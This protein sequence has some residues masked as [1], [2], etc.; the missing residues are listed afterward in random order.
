MINAQKKPAP[1][2]EEVAAK[3]L[4]QAKQ[5]AARYGY[6]EPTFTTICGDLC[7]LRFEVRS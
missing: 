4:E 3:T 5:L 6:G 1:K 2:A 7:V